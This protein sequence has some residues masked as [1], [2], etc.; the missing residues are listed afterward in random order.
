MQETLGRWHAADLFFGLAFLARRERPHYAAA[1]I[2]AVGEDIS[3]NL[4]ATDGKQLSQELKVLRR[5]LCYC[6]GL[7]FSNLQVRFRIW[8]ERLALDPADIIT[9]CAVAR[10]LRPAFVV[11]RDRQ[12][13]AIVLCIRGTHSMKVRSSTPNVLRSCDFIAAPH[14]RALTSHSNSSMHVLHACMNHMTRVPYETA[15]MQFQ[16]FSSKRSSQFFLCRAA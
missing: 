7:K 13:K 14:R 8:Q 16:C 6:L 9:Q 12:L 10:L 2:A 15:N 4:A 3:S 5:Y 11:A 1:D